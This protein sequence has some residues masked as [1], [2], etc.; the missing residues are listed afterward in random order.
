MVGLNSEKMKIRILIS[1]IAFLGTFALFPA[2]C[3]PVPTT[4]GSQPVKV[5]SVLG[6]VPPINP[7]GPIVEITLKNISGKPVVSL[8]ATLGVPR[9]GPFPPFAFNFDATPSN[10]LPPGTTIASK[11]TLIGGGFSDT[12]NYPLT[13]QGSLEGGFGFSFT[14][15]VKIEP[16]SGQNSVSQQV[17][18][19][20]SDSNKQVQTRLNET[21]AI[22]LPP[23]PL[24]GWGWQNS[25]STA[26]SLLETQTIPGL[27]AEPNP[28]GPNEFLF[29]ALKTGTSTI[30]L[31]V[32]SKP[33][34]QTETFNVVVNP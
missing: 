4:N 33:P 9:P 2:A 34:Q 30:T 7:G 18:P 17:V 14:V 21:F 27:A 12:V 24:F 10:P 8:N 22:I 3:A 26:F 6:P 15:L 23:A 20:Y 11:L 1:V 19:V 29:Q 5:V 32:A 16:P 25:D 28:Y 13:I 31:Y